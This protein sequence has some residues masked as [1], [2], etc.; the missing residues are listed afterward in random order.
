MEAMISSLPTSLIRVETVAL[1]YFFL[2]VSDKPYSPSE[3]LKVEGWIAMVCLA[4]YWDIPPLRIF[5]YK[6]DLYNG[7]WSEKD[8]GV[9]ATSDYAL[10]DAAASD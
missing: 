3:L 4:W 1:I 2:S 7:C 5:L 9:S 6:L 10:Y 8:G